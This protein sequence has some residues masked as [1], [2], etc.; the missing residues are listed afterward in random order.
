MFPQKYVYFTV[1]LAADSGK[2][3]VFFIR[4]DT[5]KY[6]LRYEKIRTKRRKDT[7]KYVNI[8]KDTKKHVLKYVNIRKD[9]KNTSLNT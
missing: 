5:K 1:L 9:T 6:V 7:K 3:Y 8:R 2:K 4:K